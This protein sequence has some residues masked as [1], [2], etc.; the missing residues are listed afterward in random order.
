VYDE[1]PTYRSETQSAYPRSEAQTCAR[2]EGQTYAQSSARSEG[3]E[4]AHTQHSTED[5]GTSG[6]SSVLPEDILATLHQMTLDPVNFERKVLSTVKEQIERSS[7]QLSQQSSARF[8]GGM[9]VSS[10][11]V[12]LC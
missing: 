1:D 12:L 3:Q 10:P 7:S 6:T 2:S 4:D 5:D 9:F 8:A 11:L